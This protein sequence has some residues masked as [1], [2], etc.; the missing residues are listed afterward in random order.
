MAGI[1]IMKGTEF[2]LLAVGALVGVLLRYNITSSALALAI[3][4]EDEGNSF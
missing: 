3:E 1:Q 4:E 2:A